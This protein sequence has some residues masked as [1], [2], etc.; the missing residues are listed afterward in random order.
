VGQ[1][2]SLKLR[3]KP[4]QAV[5]NGL[6]GRGY[7]LRLFLGAYLLHYFKTFFQKRGA[8]GLRRGNTAARAK[9]LSVYTFPTCFGV[10]DNRKGM[11]V[12]VTVAK[13]ERE[14]QKPYDEGGIYATSRFCAALLAKV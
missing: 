10:C 7:M 3:T 11:Q 9:K 13:M 2:K 5:V 4:G 8:D 1:R 6:E 14:Y 12:A